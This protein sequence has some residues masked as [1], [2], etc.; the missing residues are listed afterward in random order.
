MTV[1]Y[2]LYTRN[3]K[4]IN[5]D[6]IASFMSPISQAGF[7]YIMGSQ[8]WLIEGLICFVCVEVLMNVC[9]L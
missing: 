2:S 1:A 8:A 9:N 4:K 5:G 7:I 6:Q 3:C